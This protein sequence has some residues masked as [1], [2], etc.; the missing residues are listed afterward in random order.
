[1]SWI[2]LIFFLVIPLSRILPRIISKMRAKNKPMQEISERPFESGY[3]G[4]Y[5]KPQT[6]SPKFETDEMKVL[7]ELN[8]GTKTFE[9]IQDRTGIDGKDLDLILENLE[10]NEFM[11]VERKQGLLGPKVDLYPTDKGFKRYY[12]R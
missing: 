4:Y 9:K 12:S 8:R 7:G 2:Y 1:M 3:D 11:R 5:R 6:E 10:K